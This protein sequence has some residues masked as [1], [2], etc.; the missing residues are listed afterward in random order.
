MKTEN[1]VAKTK[2]EEGEVQSATVQF[3]FP[4]TFAEAGE[5]WGEENC[6]NLLNQKATIGVQNL[7]RSAIA[8]GKSQEDIQEV[9]AG[10][11]PGERRAGPRKDPKEKMREMFSNMTEEEQEAY[12][13]E[14]KKELA[15]R[16]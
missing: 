7:V 1:V 10:Y 5:M 8:T 16:S 4:E 11:K 2:N 13:A 9:V 3:D 6:L 12:L 14:L 15:S